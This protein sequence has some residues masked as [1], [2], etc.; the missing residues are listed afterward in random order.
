MHSSPFSPFLSFLLLW[1]NGCS[2]AHH[3]LLSVA[4][5]HHLIRALFSNTD[6]RAKCLLSIKWW[7]CGVMCVGCDVMWCVCLSVHDVSICLGQCSPIYF[8]TIYGIQINIMIEHINCLNLSPFCQVSRFFIR[9]PLAS[10]R[11]T[12]CKHNNFKKTMLPFKNAL[13]EK[14]NDVYV[15]GRAKVFI[16]KNSVK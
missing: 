8:F 12:K 9:F 11:E 5:M 13:R 10:K 2:Q 3:S 15:A 1:H 16:D 6:Q 4:E 14:D 7:T